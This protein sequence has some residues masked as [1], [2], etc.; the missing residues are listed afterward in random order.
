MRSMVYD[1]FVESEH[2]CKR[3]CEPSACFGGKKVTNN[4]VK[5]VFVIPTYQWLL[6]GI[7]LHQSHSASR[8]LWAGSGLGQKGRIPDL[9]CA[10][11]NTGYVPVKQT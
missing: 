8:Q 11:E 7:V 6:W 5:V 3:M 2:N 4:H 1:F 10:C 9:R